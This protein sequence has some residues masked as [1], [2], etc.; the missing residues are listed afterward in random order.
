M[1]KNII[2]RWNLYLVTEESIS[3]E[4]TLSIVKKSIDAGIDVIQLR[5]KNMSKRKKYNLG[6]E[7]R[8]LLIGKNISFIINDDVDLTLA[9]DA[10]GVHLGENDLHVQVVR[11]LLG[12]NKIIGKSSHDL[13]GSIKAEKNG[14][15]YIGFGSVY[16]TNSKKLSNKRKLLGLKKIENI[17]TKIDIPVVAI[18]GIKIHNVEEVIRAGA[19][20][21]A[22]ISAITQAKNIKKTIYE[23]NEIIKNIKKEV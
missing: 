10:D 7:I 14:A 22:V 17:K 9:L 21:V 5:E 18:G 1:K 23:F 12:K 6:R 19:N 3:K 13:K 11:K 20:S 15:D 4:K 2:N 8:K 16:D